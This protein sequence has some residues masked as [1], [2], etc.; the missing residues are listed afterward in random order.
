M[1]QHVGE[2]FTRNAHPQH[3]GGD[4]LEQLRREAMID[5]I[6]RGIARRRAPQ[7]IEP[8]GEVAVAPIGGDERHAGCHRA[9]EFRFG[10]GGRCDGS[11]RRRR[12][13][14][15]ADAGRRRDVH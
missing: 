15:L 7:R 11:F 5:R 10:R 12:A 3:A 9:Q 8:G 13:R 1:H 2:V 14:R 6:Q 4:R